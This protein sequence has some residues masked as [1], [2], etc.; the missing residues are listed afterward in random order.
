MLSFNLVNV[1][2]FSPTP[3]KEKLVEHVTQSWNCKFEPHIGCRDYLKI[4]S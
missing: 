2:N 4:R 1:L 3:L